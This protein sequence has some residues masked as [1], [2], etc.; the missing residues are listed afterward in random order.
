M[1]G[2]EAPVTSQMKLSFQVLSLSSDPDDRH[3]DHDFQGLQNP[4]S[5]SSV[6]LYYL[7]IIAA[8]LLS[9]KTSGLCCSSGIGSVGM[10]I[11]TGLCLWMKSLG[12]ISNVNRTVCLDGQSENRRAGDARLIDNHLG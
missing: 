7:S 8:M 12:M 5:L 6:S 2:N 10:L 4:L 3:P 11:K 1:G 9:G